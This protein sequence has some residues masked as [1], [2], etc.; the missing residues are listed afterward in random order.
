M[1]LATHQRMCRRSEI[2]VA[3]KPNMNATSEKIVRKKER[4]EGDVMSRPFLERVE[5]TLEHKTARIQQIAQVLC[6]TRS[7][8]AGLPSCLCITRS[9]VAGLPS[10]LCITRSIVAGLPSCLCVVARKVWLI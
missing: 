2:E 7:I 4:E 5:H 6:I 9:I 1:R 8:M 10:C 3:F